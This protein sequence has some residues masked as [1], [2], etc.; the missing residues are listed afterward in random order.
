MSERAF[1]DMPPL[2]CTPVYCL[3]ARITHKTTVKIAPVTTGCLS[4]SSTEDETTGVNRPLGTAR[5]LQTKN[6]CVGLAL[7]PQ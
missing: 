6:V 7:E 1:S 5:V 2:T 3:S 4:L